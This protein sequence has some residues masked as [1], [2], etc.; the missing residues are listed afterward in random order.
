[1]FK[2]IHTVDKQLR[3]ILQS[4]N[5][6]DDIVQVV[7]SYRNITHIIKQ[8]I[9]ISNR[10]YPEIKEKAITVFNTQSS[11]FGKAIQVGKLLITMLRNHDNNSDIVN[12][13]NTIQ[14]FLLQYTDLMS[15]VYD[16]NMQL[17]RI[18]VNP[19][20][21]VMDDS[22][23]RFMETVY[24]RFNDNPNIATLNESSNTSNITTLS[25]KGVDV[26]NQVIRKLTPFIDKMTRAMTSID[27]KSTRLFRQF[28]IDG[29]I[30][31]YDNVG[32]TVMESSSNDYPQVITMRRLSDNA[33]SNIKDSVYATEI[34]SII[35]E[36]VAIADI[37]GRSE[38]LRNEVSDEITSEVVDIFK[39]QERSLNA[40]IDLGEVITSI[41]KLAKEHTKT[42]STIM[43]SFIKSISLLIPESVEIVE[44]IYHVNK[45]LADTSKKSTISNK[46]T[47]NS[48]QTLV[49]WATKLQSFSNKTIAI[50]Q[51]KN[52][53]LR[54]GMTKIK[55][56]ISNIDVITEQTIKKEQ[57]SNPSHVCVVY[58][59]VAIFG[60]GKDAN[61]AWL[62]A[63]KWA[64][65]TQ[66]DWKSH[67]Q[68]RKCT[69]AVYDYVKSNGTPND[70]EVINNTITL[71]S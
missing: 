71:V 60:V 3:K 17:V 61:E 19:S 58:P 68:L 43:D 41:V 50:L 52:R 62:D 10:I 31:K 53:K 38:S 11:M 69:T 18:Q 7:N 45:V 35:E 15:N 42:T 46:V 13:M 4:G 29:L 66:V 16:S 55:D 12:I 8:T 44:G 51:T 47:E 23:K 34:T 49:D 22:T 32:G 48:I 24:K 21:F 6:H 67:M 2:E 9:E 14:D 28:D 36:Y 33:I 1:M 56:K 54:N 63:E 65:T 27:V 64:D 30:K 39:E 20:L 25:S 59:D 70:W 5:Y 37:M 40:I 57:L 26:M